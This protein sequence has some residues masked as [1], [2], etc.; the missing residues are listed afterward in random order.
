MWVLGASDGSREA[1]PRRTARPHEAADVEYAPC[2]ECAL[3]AGHAG[4]THAAWHRVCAFN[5]LFRH[6][7]DHYEDRIHR[8]P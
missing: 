8:T 1:W 2:G 6:M 5:D 4:K 7:E 3:V